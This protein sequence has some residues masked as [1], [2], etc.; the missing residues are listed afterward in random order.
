[1]E[2]TI[3]NLQYSY[4]GSPFCLNLPEY[5][6]APGLTTLIGQNGAGKSTLLK[7]VAGLIDFD[8][9]ID[10]DGENLQD[11]LAKGRLTKIGYTFQDPNDQLFNST[12]YKEVAWGLEQLKLP[13][14]EV[15]KRT[16]S[17]LDKL[18]LTEFKNLNP[19]DL[20][21]SDKKL[22]TLATVLALDPAIYLFDEPLMCLDYPSR[23]LVSQLF[24][25]LINEGKTIIMICHDMDWVAE[26]GSRICVMAGGQVAYDGLPRGFFENEQLLKENGLLPPRVYQLS[27]MLNMATPCLS[28]AEI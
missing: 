14:D 21:L 26:M 16:I 17:T 6:F 5:V 12:V 24:N 28:L 23:Q 9:K 22:L 11:F 7:A 27:K 25:E 15:E 4:P 10:F 19:Y 18:G 8:G 2:I 1:M 20:S 13:E 3:K